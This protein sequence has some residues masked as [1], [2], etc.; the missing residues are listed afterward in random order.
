MAAMVTD[1][2]SDVL[3]LIQARCTL[4]GRLVAGAPWARR[5][6]NLDAIKLCAAMEG[7]CWY[8]MAGMSAPARFASGDILVTNGQASLILASDPELL[9]GAQATEVHANDQGDWQIGHG[10]DFVMLGGKV[11]VDAR[12]QP[13]LLDGLPPLLHL[14][15]HAP[16]AAPVSW[17]LAQLAQE[18]RSDVRVGRAA[19]LDEMAQLL[20]VQVLRLH[21]ERPEAPLR[22]WLRG[23]GDRRLAPALQCMHQQPSHA[24]TLSELARASG[25]SRTSFAV[26]FR[27]VMGMP[28]LGYLLNWRMSLAERYLDEGTPIGTI[29]DRVGYASESAFS[30]AFKRAKGQAPAHYR[31]DNTGGARSAP[32]QD[33][34][35]GAP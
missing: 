23:L 6:A 13:L 27:D 25:M 35:A 5:F 20:F 16:E 28:P 31:A 3:Q 9:A 19:M 15:G 18:M 22:G 26:R 14:S 17:L 30:N 10:R 4:S 2:L 33:A 8:V 1:P 34:H 32:N 29:A 24:W 11:E 21:L 12:R 7:A